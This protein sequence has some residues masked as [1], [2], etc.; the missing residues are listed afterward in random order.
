[1]AVAKE[2]KL[3]AALYLWVYNFWRFIQKLLEICQHREYD[4]I[5]QKFG[6]RQFYNNGGQQND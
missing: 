3:A 2:K 1:M 4:Y 5:R 6:F